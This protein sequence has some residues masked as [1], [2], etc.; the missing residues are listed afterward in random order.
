MTSQNTMCSSMSPSQSVILLNKSLNSLTEVIHYNVYNVN[1]YNVPFTV[2]YMHQLIIKTAMVIHFNFSDKKIYEMWSD[3][4]NAIPL[5]IPC[6]LHTLLFCSWKSLN[7]TLQHRSL[8]MFIYLVM[9]QFILYKALFME[10]LT[11][12]LNNYYSDWIKCNNYINYHTE[13]AQFKIQLTIQ[14]YI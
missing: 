7:S 10:I 2:C 3:E 8:W 12:Y 14:D 5:V 6:G 1:K 13:V 11:Y 9:L 4:R